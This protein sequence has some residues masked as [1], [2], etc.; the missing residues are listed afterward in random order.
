[1]T[2]QSLQH[3]PLRIAMLAPFGIRPKGTLSARMLPLAQALVERGHTVTITAPPVHNPQDAGQRTVYAGV[4]VTHLD[5]PV[6]P[7]TTGTLQWIVTLLQQALAIRPDVLHLFKPK[8]YSG[9]TALL[10]RITHP[11]LPLVV[12]TD[13][14]EGQGGWNDV[15]PYPRL[16]KQLFA[17]QERDLPRRAQ[18]VTVASRTLETQV[19]GAG[20]PPE[21]VFYLPNGIGAASLPT[22]TVRRE[23][24]GPTLLLYTRFW[25]FNVSDLIIALAAIIIHYPTTRLLVIGR[26]ERGEEHDMLRLAARAGIASAIDY[27]GWIEPAAIPALLATADI[28]LVPLNDTLINRARCSVKLLELMA[29]GLPI[30]AGQVG[31]VS[32]YIEHQHSGL[33]VAPGDAA[34]LARATL[35]LLEYA[36]LRVRLGATARIAV[37][38]FRWERLVP[39]VE[40]AYYYVKSYNQHRRC[41]STIPGQ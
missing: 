25:E 12:D 23:H 7:G 29:A 17:W 21:R 20:V 31:Q 36:D 8:G 35:L 13:D 28:A 27:R 2:I 32:E 34:A 1:M 14:W 18:A 33:L 41:V 39:G 30:V 38:A 4:P 24:A 9:L 6:L 16:A 3:P 5:L 10:A 15:L 22:S 40:Q 26:G 19:W 37:N 11:R